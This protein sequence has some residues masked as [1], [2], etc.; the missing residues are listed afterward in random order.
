M[1]WWSSVLIPWNWSYF[2]SRTSFPLKTSWCIY[3]SHI[4]SGCEYSI[5]TS[6]NW[7]IK[8]Q[9]SCKDVRWVS[10]HHHVSGWLEWCQTLY[11]PWFWRLPGERGAF[12]SNRMEI[13]LWCEEQFLPSCY[14]TVPVKKRTF[15]E[16][17]AMSK[18]GVPSSPTKMMWSPIKTEQKLS[19]SSS[20]S[21]ASQAFS[22]L[23]KKNE[24]VWCVICNSSS[25]KLTMKT[26]FLL[27]FVHQIKTNTVFNNCLL[28][29]ALLQYQ[30]FHSSM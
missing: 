9:I 24:T 21:S 17:M 28:F 26:N 11:S 19:N 30:N 7:A 12:A 3:S 25:M 1:S 4:S 27:F 29:L 6:R 23:F 22:P 10:V 2:T 18:D 5:W 16:I 13:S 14:T 15:R 8:L 20:S